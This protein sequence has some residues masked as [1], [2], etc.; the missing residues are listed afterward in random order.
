MNEEQQ[1]RAR[2]LLKATLDILN[3]CDKSLYVKDVMSTT[4]IW[5]EVEGD[6]HCLKDELNELLESL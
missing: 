3:K 5:D 1:K 2:I 4:A 6:G